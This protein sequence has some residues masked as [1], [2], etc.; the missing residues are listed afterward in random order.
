[1]KKQLRNYRKS[2]KLFSASNNV[3]TDTNDWEFWWLLTLV[4]SLGGL[5]SYSFHSN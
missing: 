2:K 4:I 3:Y 1:M 5:L